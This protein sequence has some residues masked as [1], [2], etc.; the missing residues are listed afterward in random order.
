MTCCCLCSKFC[1][2]LFTFHKKTSLWKTHGLSWYVLF[3]QKVGQIK[4]SFQTFLLLHFLKVLKEKQFYH[5]LSYLK[6]TNWMVCQNPILPFF[7][8]FFHFHLIL[9]LLGLWFSIQL[10]AYPFSIAKL[11]KPKRRYRTHRPTVSETLFRF[12]LKTLL[13][14]NSFSDLFGSS[15][16]FKYSKTSDVFSTIINYLPC[17]FL[18]LFS[19]VVLIPLW[20]YIIVCFF[21]LC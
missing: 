14:N 8:L 5:M 11:A 2:I 13:P 9:F 21:N 12:S 7:I 6:L 17:H 20:F 3:Q 15:I 16:E 4:H 18:C 10:F 1:L 19:F